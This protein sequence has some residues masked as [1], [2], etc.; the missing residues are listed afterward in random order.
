MT[1]VE[2]AP[3]PPDISLQPRGRDAA[4]FRAGWLAGQASVGKRLRCKLPR[5]SVARGAYMAARAY[6]R[7]VGG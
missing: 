3:A 6:H 4:A 5:Q 7:E 2:E 1:A